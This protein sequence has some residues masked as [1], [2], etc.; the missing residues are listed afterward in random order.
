[1]NKSKVWIE[2]WQDQTE[3]NRPW[4][5]SVEDGISS[6]TLAVYPELSSASAHGEEEACKRGCSCYAPEQSR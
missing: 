1:M 3:Q 6:T 5:V 2:V 4:I